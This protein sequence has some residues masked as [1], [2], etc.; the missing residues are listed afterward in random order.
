MLLAQLILFKGDFQPYCLSNKL[1]ID[2]F[3]I[4]YN[5]IDNIIADYQ[6][7]IIFNFDTAKQRQSLYIN[8]RM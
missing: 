4:G 1:V 8:S 3:L 6:V 7:K 2:V 5:Y